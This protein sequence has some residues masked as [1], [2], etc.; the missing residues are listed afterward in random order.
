MCSVRFGAC[1]LKDHP[2][3]HLRF[4]ARLRCIT[5]K[6]R[7]EKLAQVISFKGGFFGAKMPDPA[8]PA[9]AEV[10]MDRLLVILFLYKG[11]SVT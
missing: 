10:A 4:A 11:Q 1:K 3:T 5:S 9:D 8:L 7:K 2:F 6:N